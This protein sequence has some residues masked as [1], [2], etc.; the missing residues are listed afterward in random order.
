MA[1]AMVVCAVFLFIGQR[2]W[3]FSNRPRRL[4]AT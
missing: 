2:L 4:G 1:L 3:V